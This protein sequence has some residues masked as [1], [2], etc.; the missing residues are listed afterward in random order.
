MGAITGPITVTT[1]DGSATSVS[2][3][4]VT[5]LYDFNLSITPQNAR[6]ASKS[7]VT[8]TVSVTGTEGFSNL[9]ALN[10]QGI[11]QGF[12]AYI[13][14]KTIT[15]GQS[16]TLTISTCDCSMSSPVTLTI[17]GSSTVE[18]RVVTKSAEMTLEMCTPG[19]TTLTGRVLNI[20]KQPVKGVT[21][22][23]GDSST[24]TDESGNFLLENPPPGEQVILIQGFTASTD[25]AKYP[26]IPITMNIISGQTNSLPFVPHLHFQKDYN[27]TPIN[28]AKETK[29][30]DPE[31]PGFQLRIPAGVD[32]VGWDG[33]INTKVSVIKVPIDAL[34]VPP[35]PSNVQGR[36]AYMFYFDK[37]GGGTPT[38]PIPVTAPNDLGLQPGE[39]AEL[40]YFNESP[41]L[42]EAPNE[43]SMAGTCTVSDDG[44]TVSTDPGVGIPRFCCGAIIISI[45][46]GRTGTD[47]PPSGCIVSGNASGG[48]SV[49]PSSGV[50]LHSET[51]LML[52]GRIPI[53]ITRYHRSLDSFQGPYGIG[54][55]FSYDQYLLRFGDTAVLVIPLG[56]RISFS[57]QP[58][59]N[60][61]NNSEPMYRGAVVNL[62]S[63][64]SRTLRMKDGMTYKFDGYGILIEQADRYGNRLRFIRDVEENVIQ[65]IG[66]DEKVVANFNYAWS[67]D[68][69]VVTE[70]TDF[71]GRKV[72]YTYNYIA[73]P[74]TGRLMSVTNPEGGVTQYQYDTQGRIASI[75][76]PRGNTTVNVGYD[77][78]GRVCQEQYADGGAYKFYYI[79]IDQ[80]TRPQALKLLAEAAAGGPITTPVCSG[81]Q[82]L[83]RIAYTIAVDPNGNPTTYRFNNYQQIISVTDAN[84][85]TTITDRDPFTNLIRSRT[86]ALGRKTKFTYDNNGNVTSITDPAGNRTTIEYD[87]LW[88]KPTKVIDALGNVTDMTYDTN[89][90][91]IQFRTPNSELTTINYNEYGQ[92]ISVTDPMG[93]TTRAEYDDSGNLMKIV[94]PLGSSVAMHYD[95]LSRLIES[96]D[97]RGRKTTYTYDLISRLKEVKETLTGITKFSYDINGNLLS[98]TDAKGQNITYTYNASDRAEST[99]DQLERLET[100]AYDFNGNLIRMTDRKG[101]VTNYSYDRLDKMSG[102]DYAD[103]SY[104]T[105]TYDV[106]GRLTNV[107]DSISGL[108]EYA[109][110]NAGC[111]FG[112]S[113]GATDKVIQETTPLGSISYTYNTIG[114]RTS[115]RVAGQPP[116]DFQYDSNSRLTE[117]TSLINGVAAN[118]SLRYDALGRRTSLTYPNGVVT[119]YNYDSASRLLNLEHLNPLNKILESLNY[120]YDENGN[121]TSMN[122]P[123][124]P[125]KLPDPASNTSYNSANQMLT[126]NDKSMTYDENGNLSSVTN[127]CGT[128]T[129]N[130]DAR[131]RLVAIGG[132]TSALTSTSTCETL[133]VSFKYDAFGRR[134]EKNINSK[135]I[136]YLYDGLDIVQEIENGTVSANYIR[137]L[138]IDEPLAH[139]TPN[140]SRFYQTDVLGSVIAL[141]GE[142]GTIKTQYTY[143]PF[144]KVTVYGESSDNPFQY[145]GRENDGTGLYYYRAR[146][147]SPELQR[148]I[149]EDPIGLWGGDV[150]LYGYC[151]NDPVNWIDPIG[152]QR[153]NPSGAQLMGPGPAKRAPQPQV[154]VLPRFVGSTYEELLMFTLLHRHVWGQARLSQEVERLSSGIAASTPCG[155]TVTGSLYFTVTNEINPLYIRLPNVEPKF[156]APGPNPGVPLPPNYDFK[157][158]QSVTIDIR[159]TNRYGLPEYF[160]IR[161]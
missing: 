161:K 130:W 65:I 68:R 15:R 54:T 35:P 3:F 42:G 49:E 24:T 132:F 29:V 106:V 32:I 31:L 76:D 92:A 134:V 60:Y 152:F 7:E 91:L 53:A 96:T 93:N 123:N 102:V 20:N 78:N 158:E 109:Y 88:N 80:A 56:S 64:G 38:I 11:P 116:V 156:V 61:I 143:D 142:T 28:R 26:I 147:Y 81:L 37:I 120:S 14:P 10:I 46:W 6:A 1:A 84:G 34:P 129:Y 141:T 98:V 140:A 149:S 55:Y 5:S 25:T 41:N 112:C 118:F 121:R 113:G 17:V 95:A 146:Y 19:V 101:Q 144:G 66:A 126:I 18:G 94:D 44:E 154:P 40:W 43:W 115:I 12:S 103:G 33:N 67:L 73:D 47:V 153:G 151:L 58:N 59:G 9:V 27:F 138:N 52:P 155:E 117:I 63:D 82:T 8:Y 111:I 50:F 127:S 83:S 114:R 13:S 89:R 136:Q 74:G 72:T 75:V 137:T 79:T 22:K 85:Q 23:V 90:N 135:T 4:T 139:L 145:T 104:T 87:L 62:G 71:T 110:S 86:D 128:T 39:K 45:P 160:K 157:K 51:D 16:S 125:V 131:N 57:R 77:A 100:Y 99:K 97:A 148:F 105:Y 48:K 30:E 122:R 108:T 159:G 150:H 119:N 2:D 107:Y 21:V 36:S 70:I 124:V 69:N 133:S